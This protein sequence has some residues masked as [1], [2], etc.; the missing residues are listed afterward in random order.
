MKNE[1]YGIV[2]RA[3]NIINN[4]IYIGQT[5]DTLRN[6]KRGHYNG[7]K[8]YNTYFGRALNKYIRKEFKWKIIDYA[9]NEKDLD[10]KER[11]W[12]KFYK[13]NIAKFGY[14]STSGGSHGIPTKEV[15]DKISLTVKNIWDKIPKEERKFTEEHKKRIGISNTGYK[16]SEKTKKLLSEIAKKQIHAVGYHWKMSEESRV[17]NRERNKRGMHRTPHS[18]ETKRIISIKIKK[19]WEEKKKIIND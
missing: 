11:Y 10:K 7:I 4:K 3:R 17:R 9:N 14:N 1:Y 18:E 13:S 5:I 8:K 2:Y 19:I 15:R 12:I 16:R 6:R